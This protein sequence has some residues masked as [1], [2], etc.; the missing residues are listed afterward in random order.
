[1][2]KPRV[3]IADSDSRYIM[4][5]QARF[6]EDFFE[7]ID[8]EIITDRDYFKELF[9]TPQKAEILVVSEDLYDPSLQRHN[10][11]YIFLMTEQYEEDQSVNS[12][13]NRIQ[14][15][16]SVNEIYNEIIGRSAGVLKIDSGSKNEPQIVYVCSAAGGVGKTTVALGIA[17]CLT[18]N[19]KR[20]LY[21]NASWMQSFQSLLE[22]RTAISAIDVY[23]RLANPTGAVYEE[24][25]HALRK[26]LFTYL[27]PF[28]AS[29]M[30]LGL[31]YSIYGKIAQSAKKSNDFDFIIIDG[32]SE[33]DY[34]K[35]SLIELADRVMIVTGQN[36]ASVYATN[37]LVSNINGIGS[38]K[39]VFVCN[40]FRKDEDNALISPAVSPKFTVSQYIDHFSH[41]GSLK[42]ED[43][44]ND[45]GIRKASILVI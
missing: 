26:E 35:T 32:N 15:Y 7:K 29:L 17:S 34:E 30:S 3:I 38:D 4:P 18:Q 13:L 21:I 42:I 44:S 1:M 33:F 5:L 9:L 22:N 8:L 36:E 25:K 12:R 41:Y 20:V 37:L 40:N 16:T 28:K 43:I 14:K 31:D 2:E 27:P 23:T 6:T 39:Y 19:Y 10:I 24:I 45:D 11:A